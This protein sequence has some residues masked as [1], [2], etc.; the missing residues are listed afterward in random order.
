[1]DRVLQLKLRGKMMAAILGVAVLVFAAIMTYVIRTTTTQSVE[2]SDA[3]VA[4]H[5]EIDALKVKD[6]FETRAN[7]VRTLAQAIEGIDRSAPDARMQVRRMLENVLKNDANGVSYW[8]FF[9]PNAF[10]GKDAAFAGMPGDSP[11]GRLMLPIF[12]IDGAIRR[13]EIPESEI[14][15]PGPGDYYLL[16]RNSGEET[17]LTPYSQKL[18]DGREILMTSFCMPVRLD[19]KVAGVIGTDINLTY[20]QK[21]VGEM[22]QGQAYKTAALTLVSND[23]TIVAGKREEQIG[24]AVAALFDGRP[25]EGG[26]ALEAI[27]TGTAFDDA[28]EAAGVKS[29]YIPVQIGSTKTPWSMAF[30]VA[31]DEAL[32]ATHALRT[33][34]LLAAL[35]GLLLLVLVLYWSIRR[36]TVPILA[37]KDSLIRFSTLDISGRGSEQRLREQ[38]DEIGEMAEALCKLQ[39]ALVQVVEAIR[40]E[41]L[42]FTDS[43]AALEA[44]SSSTVTAME[45]VGAAIDTSTELS[46]TNAGQLEEA[47]KSVANASSIA[48]RTAA[49]AQEGAQSI[50]VTSDLSQ[51]AIEKVNGIVREMGVLNDRTE[52]CRSSIASV[53]GAVSSITGFVNTIQ[54]L[55]NQ[56]N[57]LALNAAIEAA[58]AGE[59][60]KG[61]AV[62]AEEVRKLAEESGAA[63]KEVET[64]VKRLDEEAIT[65][66]SLFNIV[67]EKIG[68]LTE[69]SSKTQVELN[70]AL[71]QISKATDTVQYISET[72]GEQAAASQ[73][74]A[75]GID[76]ITQSTSDVLATMEEV[77][78]SSHETG[79]T[80]KEVADEALKLSDGAKR[81]RELLEKFRT[82]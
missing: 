13:V 82:H 55:A 66:Q 9:E 57:L 48:K 10:D 16:P 36:I 19:G 3:Y 40:R 5:A 50:A 30:A 70:G 76:Q 62:V 25:A 68:S 64:L 63:A 27:K 41:G 61:F 59:A 46:E 23:G 14:A 80:A 34:S 24:K 4:A 56:T 71:A 8:V 47:N 75:G 74:I 43:A 81:M 33:N 77:R 42:Q 2:M 29:R 65:S 39:G 60:G 51:Q 73:K 20:I 53:E 15:T 11:S 32:A 18:D 79:N 21:Y 37:I 45:Q 69:Q 67:N 72:F 6:F 1:M 12:R 28:D 22:N 38:R 26:R 17:L 49:L 31:E 54:G 35:I 52:A 58:R 78:A 7:R 44:L